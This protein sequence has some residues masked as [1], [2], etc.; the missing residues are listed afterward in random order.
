[1]RLI[2]N[3]VSKIGDE[4]YGITFKN[5]I[6]WHSNIGIHFNQKLLLSDL[7]N[8]NNL[9]RNVYDEVNR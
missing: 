7:I 2:D 4:M 1:M 5:N 3:K 8:S 6:L 9:L